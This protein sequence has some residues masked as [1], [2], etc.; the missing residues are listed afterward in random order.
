MS[1]RDRLRRKAEFFPD[2]YDPSLLR[3]VWTIRKFDDAYVAPHCG[4]LDSADYYERASAMR[5][6]DRVTVPTLI[7]HAKDDPFIPYSQIERREVASNPNIAVLAPGQGG[8]VGFVAAN[9]EGEDRFWAETM[10]I[11]FV[12]LINS[13]TGQN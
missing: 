7:I 2:R 12:E 9:A 3:G 1:L 8:H 10:A 4:F 6:I 5:V 11:R 13:I